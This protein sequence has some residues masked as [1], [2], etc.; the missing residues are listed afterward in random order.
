MLFTGC[1]TELI[2]RAIRDA[3]VPCVVCWR[4]KAHNAAARLLAQ[5]FFGSLARGRPYAQAFEDARSAVR[6]ATRPG[7]LANGV[8][9]MV[10]AYEL[11]DPLESSD[12]RVMAE[13]KQVETGG[14]TPAPM[15]A[16]IPLL[17]C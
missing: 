3:G 2:G 4:T 14:F 7:R 8:A 5:S 17:L 10:P 13:A 11:C 16:G 6:L 12:G 15:A 9:S 1:Q